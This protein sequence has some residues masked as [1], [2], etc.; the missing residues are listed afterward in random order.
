MADWSNLP[1]DLVTCLAKR[2]TSLEDFLVFG[3]VCRSWRSS[4]MNKNNFTGGLRHQVPFVLLPKHY[5]V[6]VRK[7]Y[8]LTKGRVYKLKLPRTRRKLC[9]SCLGWLVTVSE[10]FT[11]TLLHPLNHHAPIKLPHPQIIKTDMRYFKNLNV[12]KVVLSSS[13]SSTLDYTV[14]VSYKACSLAFC[15]PGQSENWT[16]VLTPLTLIIDLAYY[17][18]QFYG[19]TTD[20]KILICDIKNPKQAKATV[21]AQ[22]V[23]REQVDILLWNSK[24]QYLVESAE[25]LFVVFGFRNKP[26]D[27][28]YD[29]TTSACWLTAKFRVFEVYNG[30]SWS[31]SEVKNL[32]VRTLFLGDKSRSFF[33]EENTVCKPN[34]IYF[35]NNYFVRRDAADIGIFHMEDGNIEWLFDK[36]FIDIYFKESKSN[37]FLRSHLWIQPSF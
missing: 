29:D 23:P 1:Q 2:M 30:N 8:S 20:C 13:P 14:M 18:G 16:Q 3:G 26:Q 27:P 35:L 22:V 33:I 25:S 24:A 19:L 34:C 5:V 10:G 7:F 4:T 11:I 32:G 37:S 31:T 21:V 17:K 6:S 15:R 28:S 9:F 36:S 12:E